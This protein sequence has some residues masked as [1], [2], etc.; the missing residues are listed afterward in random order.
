MGPN[1]GGKTSILEAIHLA[2]V[3]RSFS[4][5]DTG[6]LVRRG[7]AGF[8]V[9]AW[10]ESS[11]AGPVHVRVERDAA[12]MR[13]K[14]NGK[15]VR[16]AAELAREVPILV[17][18]QDGVRRFRTE[19][20]E[21]RSVLDW[22][23]FHVKPEFHALWTRYRSALAQRNAALRRAQP[24]APWLSP[25]AESGEALTAAREAYIGSL[26]EHLAAVQREFGLDAALRIDFQRGWREG[27]DLKSYWNDTE[28]RDRRLGY[29]AAGPHRAN[30]VVSDQDGMG[31]E[32]F[33]AGQAKVAYLMVR[34]AQLRDL[35]ASPPGVEPI[36]FFDDLIAELDADHVAA[37]LS[38]FVR[39]PLQRFVTS[40][41][42]TA[43]L[44]DHADA[45]FHVKH[46]TI[47]TATN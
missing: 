8:N 45:V 40:P 26:R 35:L 41:S 38:G 4:T 24:V 2:S 15:A 46:G 36:V 30:V 27:V 47:T 5:R 29:T 10:F 44:D 32:Q 34:L 14:R 28:V 21:R 11:R 13:L 16:S 3:G 9:G 33:S 25:A 37:I 39:Q 31:L 7:A 18:S 43:D 19:R 20:S 42:L 1:G 12:G 22:G 23:L 6:Q 17:L